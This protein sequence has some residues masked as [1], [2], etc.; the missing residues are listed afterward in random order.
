MRSIL[1]FLLLAA[2]AALAQT[3]FDAQHASINNRLDELLERS[4]AT[5]E[6]EPATPEPL[7]PPLSLDTAIARVERLRPIVEPILRSEGVPPEL[8]AVVLVESAGRPDALSPKNALG[9]WQF[10]APTARRYGLTVAP[11]LDQRLHIEHST[12]A[13]A[14]YLRD[15]YRQFGAWPLAL[16]AYNAGEGR[17]SKAVERAGTRDFRVVSARGL[18]PEE[19]RRYVPAVIAA[20]AVLG[21][22]VPW[23]L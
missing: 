5:P 17:V 11:G 15:L 1:V 23:P 22:S 3:P 2:S 16:A 10:I 6:P 14:R 7:A 4:A 8:L 12:R 20:I 18:L 13:A 21:D 9:L 19:T